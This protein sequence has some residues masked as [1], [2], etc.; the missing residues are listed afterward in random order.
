[1]LPLETRPAATRSRW[2]PGPAR[3]S[4]TRS[5]GRTSSWAAPA[6]PS[7]RAGPQGESG[8]TGEA[9]ALPSLIVTTADGTADQEQRGS[10]SR[11]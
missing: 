10:R 9:G 6:R 3:S 5:S 11:A 2:A 1:M 7:R 4:T 8:P